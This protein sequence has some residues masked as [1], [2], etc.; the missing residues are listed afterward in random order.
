MEGLTRWW[1]VSQMTMEGFSRTVE[2]FSRLCRKKDHPMA[3]VTF[4]KEEQ[5]IRVVKGGGKT[6][7]IAISAK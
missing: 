1:K 4:N 6:T 2:G 7:L 5:P 3:K